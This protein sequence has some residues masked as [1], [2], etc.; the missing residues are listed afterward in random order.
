ML[1]SL[2]LSDK[3]DPNKIYCIGVKRNPKGKRRTAFNEG[4]IKLLRVDLFNIFKDD[5]TIS[6]CY[7]TKK[8]EE[9]ETSCIIKNFSENKILY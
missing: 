9:K 6:F 7:S 4:K 8:E 5:E 1:S 3:E 2:S